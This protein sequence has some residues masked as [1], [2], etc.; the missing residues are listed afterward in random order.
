MDPVQR[1][2]T[3]IRR[4]M[5]QRSVRREIKTKQKKT[6]KKTK[7]KKKKKKTKKKTKKT[8][9]IAI[10]NNDENRIMLIVIVKCYGWLP[11]N[12]MIPYQ[13]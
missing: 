9:Y 5:N 8:M 2:A 10:I 13:R 7:E 4:S 6:K 11:I 3:V 1:E 12:I